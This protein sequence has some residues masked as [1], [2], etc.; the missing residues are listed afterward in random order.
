[1]TVMPGAW[2]LEFHDSLEDTQVLSSLPHSVPSAASYRTVEEMYDECHCVD[3]ELPTHR[4]QTEWEANDSPPPYTPFEIVEHSSSRIRRLFL[5]DFLQNCAATFYA[6]TTGRERE[7]GSSG[8]I[9]QS[10]RSRSGNSN[11]VHARTRAR[12]TSRKF[13]ISIIASKV[14][15][16]VKEIKN[17]VERLPET[18]QKLHV[19]WQITRAKRKLEWL[20]RN[21]Y[22]S[23]QERVLTQDLTI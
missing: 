16:G 23:N 5:I 17:Q 18:A 19:G 4:P 8:A 13:C 9:A 3:S 11:M 21:G 14:T 12:T 7:L 15:N 1:M 22:L 2:P 20:Q 10:N 6:I